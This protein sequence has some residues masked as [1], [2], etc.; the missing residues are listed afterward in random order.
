MEIVP[1]SVSGFHEGKNGV[2]VLNL[3]SVTYPT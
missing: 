3:T 1:V 2:F